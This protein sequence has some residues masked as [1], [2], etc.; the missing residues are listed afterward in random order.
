MGS[1]SIEFI[2][3]AAISALSVARTHADVYQ[4]FIRAGKLRE[5]KGLGT[6]LESADIREF[7]GVVR[8]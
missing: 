3:K 6:F 8:V 5:D 1:N 2:S 4:A 7:A